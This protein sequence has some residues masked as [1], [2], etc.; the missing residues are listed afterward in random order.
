MPELTPIDGP[1]AY[2]LFLW[3]INRRR[4]HSDRFAALFFP[5]SLLLSQLKKRML[6]LIDPRIFV[7]WC[8]IQLLCMYRRKILFKSPHSILAIF[9][10]RVFVS[11]AFSCSW[12]VFDKPMLLS[13]P[14]LYVQCNTSQSSSLRNCNCDP[15]YLPLVVPFLSDLIRHVYI[16]VVEAVT[17]PAQLINL[18]FVVSLFFP[19]KPE[20][21]LLLLF[22]FIC[23]YMCLF[24]WMTV[25]I[26]LNID[27]SLLD[28]FE[29]Y[30]LGWGEEMSVSVA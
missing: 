28:H 15:F 6:L 18:S 14:L 3:K 22:I 8:P 26:Y 10:C 13:S 16:Y 5:F 4:W 1:L 27:T 25:C 30:S 29:L 23:V 20:P 19:I 11:C 24:A 2:I 17:F 7:I 21:R 9:V 12:Q